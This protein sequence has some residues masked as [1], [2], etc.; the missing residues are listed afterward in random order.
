[1]PENVVTIENYAKSIWQVLEALKISQVEILG[2]HTGSKVGIEMSLQFP[3]RVEKLL[4]ISLSTLTPE[5]YASKK[6]S[7]APLPI[8]FPGDELTKWWKTLKGYYDPDISIETLVQKY[9]ISLK[10]G[11]RF[12]LGFAASHHYNAT[13]LEKLACLGVP[14]ALINPND[15]LQNVTPLAE[16]FIENCVLINEPNWLPGFLDIK[17]E[18]VLKTMQSA[19]ELLDNKNKATEQS[20]G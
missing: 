15:D 17:P 8:R 12:H 20:L 9:T 7:F 18:D 11:P 6:T 4:C 5:Q 3:Q 2:Y 14:T 19:F 13:V 1:M 10:S 16:K